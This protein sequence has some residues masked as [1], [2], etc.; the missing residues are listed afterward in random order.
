MKTSTKTSGLRV[1]TGIK[2]GGFK[3][4]H[5]SGLRVKTGIKAGGFKANHNTS[6]LQG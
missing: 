4:N 6:L 1:K 3:A 2:A 5:T